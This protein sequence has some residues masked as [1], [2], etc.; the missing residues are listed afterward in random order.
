MSVRT[1]SICFK[2]DPEIKALYE[3]LKET[4]ETEY[5]VQPTR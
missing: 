2:D 5:R 3:A 1:V 4:G